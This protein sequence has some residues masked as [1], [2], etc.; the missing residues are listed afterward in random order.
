METLRP[1]PSEATQPVLS[2]GACTLPAYV[3]R[4][5][6]PARCRYWFYHPGEEEAAD[7]YVTFVLRQS[8]CKTVKDGGVWPIEDR[9]ECGNDTFVRGVEEVDAAN[10]VIVW[11]CFA[12][13]HVCTDEDL[14]HRARCGILTQTD[15][16]AV[17][18]S[19]TADYSARN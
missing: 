5:G 13:G 17:C 2:C 12:C 4:D 11:A 10:D 7:A 19:C 3:P 14:D 18:D 1:V 15:G 8:R 9:L 16:A 6:E